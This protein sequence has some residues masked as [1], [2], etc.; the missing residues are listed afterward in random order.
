MALKRRQAS[1]L[2]LKNSKMKSKLNNH[3][4]LLCIEIAK[5]ISMVIIETI[6]KS[7]LGR[8]LNNL[9]QDSWLMDD[10]F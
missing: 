6:I 10:T 7:L 1:L 2:R 8:R 4:T 9:I 5:F 3:V